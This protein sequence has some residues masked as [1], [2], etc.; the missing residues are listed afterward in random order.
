MKPLK[1][2]IPG[3]LPLKTVVVISFLFALFISVGSACAQDKN[4]VAPPD[5][6]KA[7]VDSLSFTRKQTMYESVTFPGRFIH[8]LF[9]QLYSKTNDV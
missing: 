3:I 7:D 1:N 6:A 9:S 5:S 4:A 8:R 2:N